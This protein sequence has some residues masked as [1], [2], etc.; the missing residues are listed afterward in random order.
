MGYWFPLG[1]IFAF[2][3]C[4]VITLGQ[5]YEAFN[6]DTIDWAGVVATYVGLPLF[7]V[8]WFGYKW[9]KGSHIVAYKDM[10]VSGLR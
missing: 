2:V 4:L 9:V 10:D 8:I 5:N 3:L 7:L 1:P 6:K